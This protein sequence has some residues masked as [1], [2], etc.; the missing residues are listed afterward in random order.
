MPDPYSTHLPVIVALVA[1][2][3]PRRVVDLGVGRYSTLAWAAFGAEVWAIEDM[4]QAW[5]NVMVRDLGAFPKIHWECMV[6]AGMAHHWLQTSCPAAVDVV[7]VDNRADARADC[8]R[9]GWHVAHTVLAHDTEDAREELYHLRA[10]AP[11]AGWER[12]DFSG[13]SPA[14]SVWTRQPEI[15]GKLRAFL[16]A[17]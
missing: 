9:A 7:C 5:F 15:A 6:G 2:C 3:R 1:A 16:N 4:H 11:P 12:I 10:L 8:V 14:S 13:C 17:R